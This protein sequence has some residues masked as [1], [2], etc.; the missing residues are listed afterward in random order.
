[1][2]RRPPDP[3]LQYVQVLL[4]LQVFSESSLEPLAGLCTGTRLKFHSLLQLNLQHVTS[5]SEEPLPFRVLRVCE[6][7]RTG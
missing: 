1:M 3:W 6:V 7:I 4:S 2:S 5:L